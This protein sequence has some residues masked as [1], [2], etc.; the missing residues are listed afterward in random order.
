MFDDIL[1]KIEQ[2]KANVKD[3]TYCKN[4]LYVE[5]DFTDLT[6]M[7][8]EAKQVVKDAKGGSDVKSTRIPNTQH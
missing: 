5:T 6:L 1:K 3:K 2:I 8:K 7:V 4:S